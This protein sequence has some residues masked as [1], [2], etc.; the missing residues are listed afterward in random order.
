MHDHNLIFE[1]WNKPDFD[2]TTQARFFQ[3]AGLI[4]GL[5]F[6]MG[7]AAVFWLP[8]MF[9]LLQASV[10]LAWAKLPIGLITCLPLGM[11][12]GW[13]AARSGRAWVGTLIW[14]IAGAGIMWIAGHIP[15]DGVSFI[16]SLGDSY[17]ISRIMY[18]FSSQAAALTSVGMAVGILCGFFTGLIQAIVIE[19]AWDRS[20]S[21]NRLSRRSLLVL[22]WGLIPAILLGFYADYATQ[23]PIRRPLVD[24][25]WAIDM[26]RDPAYDLAKSQLNFLAPYRSQ[27]TPAYTIYWNTTSESVVDTESA[28]QY[29]STDVVDVVFD[30]GLILRCNYL[31]GGGN[32]SPYLHGG[33]SNCSSLSVQLRDWLTQIMTAGQVACSDCGIRID[34]DVQH[35]L[36]ENLSTLGVLHEVNLLQ[37][38]G[39]WIYE[40]AMFDTGRKIDCRFVG[41]TP[42]VVNSCEEAK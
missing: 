10:Y 14:V 29:L 33:V 28:E 3:S 7:F 20:S 16:A 15:Y 2:A 41:D 13:L 24:V 36:K 27:L 23:A 18:P 5:I 25:A 1:S 39:G 17:P 42:V 19:R 32:N 34:S 22:S 8:D 31:A 30:S 40:R 37:H 21:A 4:Y 26:A 9:Q 12:A 38:R 6:G 11:F 35:W